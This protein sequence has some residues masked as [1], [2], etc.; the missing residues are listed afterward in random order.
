MIEIRSRRAAVRG[1]G[2]RAK[3]S[4]ARLLLTA[5]PADLRDPQS[6]L[7]IAVETAESSDSPNSEVLRT[8]ALA[9]H[10]TGDV[11]RA[12]EY[13]RRALEVLPEGLPEERATLEA[14]LEQYL[15]ELSGDG[16]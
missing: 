4:Y 11:R 8:V 7:R 9:Y 12:V 10:S 6:A 16:A 5:E 13:Q 2:A 1:A 15:S 3:V 14:E